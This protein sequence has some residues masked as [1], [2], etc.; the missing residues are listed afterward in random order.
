MALLLP[1]PWYGISS[2]YNPTPPSLKPSAPFLLCVLVLICLA[3][4]VIGSLDLA[5]IDAPFLSVPLQDDRLFSNYQILLQ[6][7][8]FHNPHKSHYTYLREPTV[9]DSGSLG[10]FVSKD[11][12]LAFSHLFGCVALTHSIW[13]PCPQGNED[14][15]MILDFG[16]ANFTLHYQDL[17]DANHQEGG[18]CASRIGMQDGQVILGVPFFKTHLLVHD[19]VSTPF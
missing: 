2:W 5:L 19:I 9:V 1:F 16:P 7:I 6:R 18:R 17:V 8:I 14:A 13:C 15:V 4:L 11:M 12:G 3:E 10:I